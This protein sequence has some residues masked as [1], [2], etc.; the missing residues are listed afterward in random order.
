[1]GE[2]RLVDARIEGTG[3]APGRSRV[4]TTGCLVKLL[5][6]LGLDPVA[7]LEEAGLGPEAFAHPDNTIPD[8]QFGRLL[9]HASARSGCSDLGVRLARDAGL[10][11]LGLAGR[12]AAHA[13]TLG[14]ALADLGRFLALHDGAGLVRLQ[15]H[16]ALATLTYALYEPAQEG[17]HLRLQHALAVA[18]C[19]LRE[20][21]GPGW[22]P[23]EVQLPFRRGREEGSLQRFF[24]AP[25]RFDADRAALVF[26][27]AWLAQPPASQDAAEHRRLLR[28]AETAAAD[29]PSELP[30]VVRRSVRAL[31]LDGKAS[32]EAVARSFSVHRR[33]LDRRLRARGA[34]F[35][36]LADG[37]RYELA[38]ELLRDTDLPITLVAA[39][40]QYGDASA[41]D[42]AFRRWSGATPS[43]WRQ[44]ARAP[45]VSRRESG[46]PPRLAAS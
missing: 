18:C 31:L 1:M 5:D 12:L 42:H 7:A 39:A 14:L 13:P 16:G 46:A 19:V 6:E 22:A 3:A 40:L 33:T 44:G 35:R 36:A 11:S 37:V 25:L 4:G 29:F 24:R 43:E 32:I 21:C 27:C 20:I 17:C 26:P 38:R 23:L 9:L 41:F 30:S 2:R 15:L 10:A 8:A 28:L 45:G 34:S